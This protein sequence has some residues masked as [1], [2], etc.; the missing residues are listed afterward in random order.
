MA[1]EIKKIIEIDTGNSIT[2]LKEYKKHIDELRGALLGLDESSQEYADIAAE[3]KNEQDKLNEVMKVGKKDT[4]AA[5][6]SYNKLAQT[7]AEL[8][9]QWKATGDEAERDQ[10]GKQIVEINDKLKELDASTGN[11]QRNVGNY[12]TAFS[13]AFKNLGSSISGSVPAVGKL[14][15]ALKLLAANPIGAVIMAIVVAVK[16][17]SSALK[18]SEEQ[19]GKMKVATAGLR[20]VIDGIKNAISKVVEVIV[21][22]TEKVNNFIMKIL[23]KLKSGFEALGWDKMA[24]KMGNTIQ[25]MEEYQELAQKEVDINKKRREIALEIAKTENQ[26]S[27][28]RAKIADKE[29]YSD[30]ERLAF[31]EKWEKAEK[32][33]ADLQIQLAQEEYDI[34]KKN[35]SLTE[36]STADLDKE[37]EALINLT[38]AQGS[39]NEA[40]RNV[41][42]Q[43]NTLIKEINP[44][45][46]DE[47]NEEAAAV[48][49]LNENLEKRLEAEQKILD[50]KAERAEYDVEY[51]ENLIGNEE[52]KAERIYEIEHQ[53]ILDKISLQEEYLSNLET[54]TEAEIK[55]AQTLSDY[56]LQL[57][58]LEKK[59]A[60]ETSEAEVEA[61]KQAAANKKKVMQGTLSVS[62]SIFGA[63]AELSEEGSEEQKAF[64]I[65]ETTI[66]TIQAAVAAFKS[67]AEIPV[68]GP[69]LGAAAAAAATAFGIANI[70][71]IK[72]TKKGKTTTP[73]VNAAPESM[74]QTVSSAMVSPL[75]N[76]E[77][78]LSKMNSIPVTQ[79]SDR[80]TQNIKVY[81]TESDITDATH[82]AEVRDNNATF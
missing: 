75:L 34:I 43:K 81:V 58:K 48:E 74:Q 70:N 28:L 38:Q 44:E 42:K 49:N 64:A 12:E 71:K 80:G 39:Y 79:E 57:Y 65:M 33:K 2:S 63:M 15:N 50:K 67:M 24:E 23:T 6:G 47:T 26:I 46:I 68:V 72:N 18:G 73:N 61:A 55:A 27:E 78:D 59:K 76:E 52:E 25:K 8:K 13:N 19:S 29:K 16:A 14:G 36:S 1:D 22:L 41:I 40:M 21:T 20:V 56:K 17:L 69:A 5:D 7:M 66:N 3:I 45:A 37:N 10:L 30:E 9:K 11:F 53:L 62:A 32:H 82:K 4:D 35:N 60:Y 54:G 77:A 51:D 31:I